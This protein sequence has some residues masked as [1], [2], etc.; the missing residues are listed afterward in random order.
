MVSNVSTSE[1]TV[2][3]LFCGAGGFS[4]GFRQQGFKIIMGIDNWGPAIETYNHN[5]SL[6]C[7]T[8]N[9]LDF[10]DDIAKIE[11]L[12]NTSIILGS[13]PCVSFSSSNRSGK[14]DKSLGIM[15]TKAF[16]KV[17]AVKKY[18]H[19]SVLKAWFME[20]VTKSI[21]HLEPYYTFRHLGLSDWA[22]G[23]GYN[24]DD[25]AIAITRNCAIINS[26]AYGS[27]QARRRSITGE[28][29]ADG[30]LIIPPPT[31]RSP[32]SKEN[33]L[34]VFRTLRS[35]RTTL[36]APNEK[37][38]ER[39]ISDPLY[40][41]V[42]IQC[43]QLTDHFY[44]TGLYKT[45]WENSRFMK[46]SHPYMGLMSFPENEE[47][48]SRT[49]TAT[50]IGTSREAIIY[51][52]EYDRKGNG[53]YRTPTVREAATLMSF[54]ITYQ[55]IGS[56]GAKWR[57]VGNAVCPSV[58]RSLAITVGE[59]LG[60]SNSTVPIVNTH[61]DLI[62]IPN[63]NTFRPRSFNDQPKRNPGARFRRHPFKDGNITVTLSNYDIA[64]NE[65]EAGRWLTSVQY[66]NGDGFPSIAYEDGYFEKIAH[67]I[68]QFKNGPR[69]L[70]IINNGFS[71]RIA[72]SQV[73][74]KMHEE[75]I[76][77]S[78]YL[79]PTALV[80]KVA[81]IIHQLDVAEK[82]EQDANPIFPKKNAVPQKQIM[83]LYAINKICSVANY[84]GNN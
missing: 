12:P 47:N 80:E 28:V 58:S 10:N 9:I 39:Y 42:S 84:L 52:S 27:P 78:D 15:L 56:E 71:E 45:E 1:H 64:K 19:G 18:Q 24:P 77:D 81:D 57:L 20:N 35:I 25:T 70:E 83:A 62:N 34:P 68:T 31:H 53:E 51:Q 82:Y 11:A 14:A 49:V 67:V 44:D 2:L 26:A 66:G 41:H 16:L 74:Q 3:D 4:E 75:Q 65:K 36:P 5:F 59:V 46:Q 22:V 63:L 72:A 69:F 38:S 61:I 55:F 79:A 29:I 37:R 8:R 30:R 23:L 7:K 32:E 6:D 54:P 17:V 21:G 33:G 76:C 48:P 73:M 60:L 40:P 13:P 43:D 50:K